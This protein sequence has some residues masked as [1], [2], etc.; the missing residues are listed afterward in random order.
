MD[1]NKIWMQKGKIGCTFA[2]L[3]AKNPEAIGWKTIADARNLRFIVPYD[4]TF[5]LSLQFPGW[6][7]L[8]VY[9]W[10]IANHFYTEQITESNTGLRYKI[11]K[12][13]SWV[14]YFGPDSHVRTRR[15][16]IPELMMCIKLPAQYYFKVG[17][18]GVLH[19]A[20]ASIAGLKRNKVDKLWETSYKNTEKQL[21]HKPG[22]SEASK[23]TF[24]D[25]ENSAN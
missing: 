11:G 24:K 12:N 5:I 19:L 17:F 20:H 7:K 6:T 22:V 1:Q 10:A 3:F 16:P 25:V 21:G 18:T 2:A 9:S 14:Q 15:A 13:V 23:T 8:E 4:G